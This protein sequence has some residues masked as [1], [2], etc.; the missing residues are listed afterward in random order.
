MQH[1][2]P[3]DMSLMADEN[4]L[5]FFVVEMHSAK[6]TANVQISIDM[7]RQRQSG[8]GYEKSALIWSLLT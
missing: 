4:V 8:Y 1:E 2:F 5:C 3:H 7:F 6:R